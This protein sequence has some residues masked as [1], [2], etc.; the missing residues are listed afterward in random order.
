MNIETEV[1]KF[2]ISSQSDYYFKLFAVLILLILPSLISQLSGF[3]STFEVNAEI[4]EE[5]TI[6][7]KIL[8]S[9]LFALCIFLIWRFKLEIFWSVSVYFFVVYL[10]IGILYSD[11]LLMTLRGIFVAI[12]S[13]MLWNLL[14]QILL[15][16]FNAAKLVNLIPLFFLFLGSLELFLWSITPKNYYDYGYMAD[17]VGYFFQPNL[18]AKLLCIGIIFQYHK[19]FHINKNLKNILVIICLSII[20][21][22]TGS[23]TS[24][25]ALLISIFFFH[26]FLNKN[27]FLNKVKYSVLFLGL[28]IFFYFVYS[29]FFIKNDIYGVFYEST[30]SDRIILWKELLP[31]MFDN[32]LFGAGINSFFSPNIFYDFNI[33]LAGIHNGYLQVFQSLGLIGIVLTFIILYPL[34]KSLKF[35]TADINFEALKYSLVSSWIYFFIVNLTEGE[36][37]NFRSSFWAVL[38]VLSIIWYYNTKRIEK[39]YETNFQ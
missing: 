11:S 29:D 39:L 13:L 6:S 10:F 16:N 38:M 18:L 5:G 33:N 1:H 26:L 25:I 36:L 17:F 3:S 30:L 19:I 27:N 23:R 9:L 7:G 35:K 2:N 34:L 21:I 14:A 32:F 31:L 37:G 28:I 24:L 20:L 4:A 8:F 22:L 12:T 15:V